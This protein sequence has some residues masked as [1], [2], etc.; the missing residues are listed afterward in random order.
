MKTKARVIAFY[1]PQF[2][3]VPENDRWW[4]KGFTE[5]TNV[6]KAKPLFKGHHQPR[7]PTDL[8]FYDL[9]VPEVREQQAQ[10][11][12]EAGIEGFC[13]WHYWF[14]N[15]KQLLQ[16]PFNEVLT[17]GE[18]NFP[19]CLGWANHSW[20]TG[21]W[22]RDGNNHLIVEQTYGGEQDYKQHF[23]YVLPAFHDA[24]YMK[25]EG[26]PIF[27]VFDP[28]TL[29][30]DFIPYWRNM[31]HVNGLEGIHFVAY[32]Q[33]AL[34]RPITNVNGE[35]V[36]RGFFDPNEADKYYDYLVEDL[37]FDAVVPMGMNRA[38][39]L[40]KN[41][42]WFTLQRHL[43]AKLHINLANTY[44]Y[45]KIMDRYYT[46]ADRR[47]NVY[48]SLIPQWDRS[49]R[50]GLNG[51]YV[52]STPENFGKAIDKAL[53]L[54][55]NKS[56]ERQIIFLKSWNEWAEGNYVEPDMHYGH[57]FLDALRDRLV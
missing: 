46:A 20:S 51:I 12:R 22:T 15:G 50:S 55:K 56:D 21:T 2:H 26:K 11:A 9:R 34:G 57:G 4:G 37:G 47:E 45:A 28:Y 40:C 7:I 42:F 10:L 48:P 36:T 16:R 30:R 32:T 1:L 49:P 54:V 3:P 13:Y 18:P 8:G 35:Q 33:N 23:G 31:A 41:A 27:V 24:R 53:D 38:E 14:G 5:W 29:P 19:F 17:S 43:S 6:V 52:N 25:V 39:V 44:D